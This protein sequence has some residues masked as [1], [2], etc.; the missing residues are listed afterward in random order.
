M[1]ACVLAVLCTNSHKPVELYL[2]LLVITIYLFS[3]PVNFR[4]LQM[5]I[6]WRSKWES[7]S[8]GEWTDR[9]GTNPKEHCCHILWDSSRMDDCSS[10]L[11]QVQLPSWVLNLFTSSVV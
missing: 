10:H 4:N 2:R 6:L 5:A 1:A 9:P 8:L 3:S 11:L 7:E